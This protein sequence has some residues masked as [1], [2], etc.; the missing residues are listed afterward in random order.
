VTYSLGTSVGSLHRYNTFSHN[1]C[2]AG[3]SK[4]FINRSAQFLLV[5]KQLTCIT[6]AAIEAIALC[7]FLRV[8]AGCVA[9]LTTEELSQ[10]VLTGP[11]MGTPN[12]HNLYHKLSNNSTAMCIAINSNPKVEVSIVF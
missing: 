8:E 4:G 7:F 5:C 11:L 3:P 6:F 2:K 9:F 10:K 12:M 1:A